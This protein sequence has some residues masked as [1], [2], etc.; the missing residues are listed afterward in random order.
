[1]KQREVP[2]PTINPV[3]TNNAPTL[4][5]TKPLKTSPSDNSPHPNNAVG[6]EPIS[7]INLAFKMARNA[8]QATVVLPTNAKVEDELN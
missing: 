7:R 6:R 1:M 8:M 5:V 4:V 3:V 2:T